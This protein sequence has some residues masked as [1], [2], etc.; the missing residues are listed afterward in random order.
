MSKQSERLHI[1]ENLNGHK[2]Y[3][4]ITE[5]NYEH[6]NEYNDIKE[7]ITWA[8]CVFIDNKLRVTDKNA[9]VQE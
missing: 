9:E 4:K 5:S 2:K 1:K 7:Y 6:E 8:T 3:K